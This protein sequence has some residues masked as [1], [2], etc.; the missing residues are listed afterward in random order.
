MIR[1]I[2][3][4]FENKEKHIVVA[5]ARMSPPTIGHEKA[6]NKI[7]Q[8]AEKRGADHMLFVSHSH[9]GNK[10]PLSP[11]DKMKHLQ[12]SF[13]TTNMQIT[14]PKKGIFDH[15]DELHKKG[16]THVTMVAGQDRVGDYKKMFSRAKNLKTKVV[17]A[18]KRSDN[19]KDKTESI[20]GTKMRSFVKSDDYSSFHK[21]LPTNLQNNHEHA[22]DLWN[23]LKKGK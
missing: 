22:K 23:D 14:S 8:Y 2:S 11:E 21:N 9:D 18:G 7:K 19:S 4:L 1:F 6:V 17:S 5:M 20:S 16:Y 3:Y 15:I 12:R 13:P 10:N